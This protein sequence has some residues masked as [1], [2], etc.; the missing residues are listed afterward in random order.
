MSSRRLISLALRSYFTLALPCLLLMTSVRLLMSYEFL[1]FEYQ[2]PGFPVD[3]FG[4][5]T[6]D[7]LEYGMIA[8]TFLFSAEPIDRLAERRLPGEKCWEPVER[9]SDC[10]LFGEAELGHLRD[11]KH[12][13]TAL[14]S[15]AAIFLLVAISC[16]LAAFFPPFS[17]SMRRSTRRD[18][19]KG[20]ARGA[21]FT[22]AIFFALAL[23][24]A[25]SWDLAFDRFHDLFF[26]EGTWRFPFSD[27][28]IRLY[29]ERLFVDAAVAI[30]GFAVAG[31]LLT[32]ATAHCWE[33]RDRHALS[34][35]E[36]RHT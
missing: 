1:R 6:E 13:L 21:T 2:R 29:P 30:A 4:F 28:L 19:R 18:I 36:I 17:A 25:L 34:P 20:L 26:A 11:V 7:R 31:S 16:L 14:F 12:I 15:L 22:L 23:I 8:I 24:S 10:A 32:L 27:S 5:T 35:I 3:I 33:K 9:L